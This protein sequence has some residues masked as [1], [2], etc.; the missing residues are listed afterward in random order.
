MDVGA[1]ASRGPGAPLQSR[2]MNVNYEISSKDK[3]TEIVISGRITF[4][5]H[6]QCRQM[7]DEIVPRPGMTLTVDLQDVDFIDSAGL[8]LLLLIKDK[9]EKE[10]GSTVLR[11]AKDGQIKKMLEIANFDDLVTI[12]S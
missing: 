12:K 9:G 8:G 7:V 2:G 10:G 3:D 11:V 4:A 6:A 5:E 1:F